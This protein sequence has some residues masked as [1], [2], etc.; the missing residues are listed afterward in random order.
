MLKILFSPAVPHK[1]ANTNQSIL[2]GESRQVVDVSF[3][4]CFDWCNERRTNQKMTWSDSSNVLLTGAQRAHW[5]RVK[6]NFHHTADGRKFLICLF[7][8]P[9]IFHRVGLERL[10]ICLLN[11]TKM[12]RSWRY[13]SSLHA[14][15]GK[16]CTDFLTHG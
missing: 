10:D 15:I 9:N 8:F 2:T 12:C 5:P 1:I 13:V 4:K 3:L 14:I 16:L 6:T 11:C 7:C